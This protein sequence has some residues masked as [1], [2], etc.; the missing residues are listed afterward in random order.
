MI[1]SVFICS[2]VMSREKSSGIY[3]QQ[4]ELIFAK[5]LVDLKTQFFHSQ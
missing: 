3:K 4:C 1:L 2:V 5:H